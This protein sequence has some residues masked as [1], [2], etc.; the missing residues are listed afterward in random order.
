[1]AGVRKAL[2]APRMLVVI[3]ACQSV[4]NRSGCRGRLVT[5]HQV[6]SLGSESELSIQF[7]KTKLKSREAKIDSKDEDAKSSSF[8]SLEV[9]VR[10]SWPPYRVAPQTTTS[11]LINTEVRQGG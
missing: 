6:L 5:V 4:T 2:T 7:E 3:Y 1:M 9:A 8:L 11:S 10:S